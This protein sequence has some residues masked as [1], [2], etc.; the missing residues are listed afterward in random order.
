MEKL[1]YAFE[2]FIIIII[3]IFFFLFVERLF[4]NCER[5]KEKENLEGIEG[6]KHVKIDFKYIQFRTL[7]IH[8]QKKKKKK[9][10]NIITIFID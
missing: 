2:D 8:H 4:P 6:K 10:I 3:I 7:F 1:I 9:T 5:M